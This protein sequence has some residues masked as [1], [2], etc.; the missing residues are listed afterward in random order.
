M[1]DGYFYAFLRNFNFHFYQTVNLQGWRWL[2]AE[3]LQY[4]QKPLKLKKKNLAY[5]WVSQDNF[6]IFLREEYTSKKGM[7][8]H[9]N[10]GK[11][12][13]H[14]KGKKWQTLFF[15]FKCGII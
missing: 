2:Q 13:L 14:V 10:R 3:K 11:R 9:T 5:L 4:V 7:R 6:N 15:I 12:Q 1:G 8:I